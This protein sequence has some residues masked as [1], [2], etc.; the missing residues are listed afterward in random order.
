MINKKIVILGGIGNS[1]N[2]VFNALNKHYGI[3]KVIIEEKESTKL[4]LKRR[5]KKLGLIKVFGQIIFQIF[6]AKPLN[7]I[8]SKRLKEIALLNNLDMQDIPLEK[9]TQ[10]KSINAPE[11]LRLIQQIKPDLIIVN[12]TRIISKKILE[13]VS[14]KLINTHAGIT[15]KYRGVHGSYWAL[16][17]NDSEN[18]G[19]TIHFVD[20]GI[21]TGKILL[22]SIIEPTAKDNF[23]TYPLL[24]LAVGVKLL[25]KVIEDYFE[26][27][28]KEKD[29]IG[30]SKLYYHPTIF[31]YLYFRLF[32]NVK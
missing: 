4:F 3:Y 26:G 11:S 31:Q 15:P 16:V 20:A 6:I 19:V 29:S 1:T 30:E 21:D 17:N 5:L 25:I 27:T 24:Q 9:L 14:C 8:S 7:L 23:C 18:N 13:S 32:K 22:Q 10:V 12:G 28:T 2:I